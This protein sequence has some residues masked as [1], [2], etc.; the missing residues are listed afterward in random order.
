M[1]FRHYVDFLSIKVAAGCV[2]RTF[3]HDAKML[4]MLNNENIS[5]IGMSYTRAWL[6]PMMLKQIL[7]C[8]IEQFS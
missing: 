6:A 4:T 2:V 8:A 7:P 5:A 3:A 1:V